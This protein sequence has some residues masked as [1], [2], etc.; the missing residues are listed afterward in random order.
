MGTAVV[1]A[2]DPCASDKLVHPALA[3]EKSS[4]ALISCALG[5]A[6]SLTAKSALLERE[7]KSG[8]PCGERCAL[9]H[10]RKDSLLIRIGKTRRGNLVG[11]PLLLGVCLEHALSYCGILLLGEALSVLAPLVKRDK[12]LV[13]AVS[14]L[15]KHREPFAEQCK[16]L[17]CAVL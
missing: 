3:L 12:A 2:L 1:C 7:I 4:R 6:A 17:P 13:E 5:L 9:V 8:Q 14:F 16:L 11:N 10:G 15:Y